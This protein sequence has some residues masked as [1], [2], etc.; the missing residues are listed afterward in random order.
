[1]TVCRSSDCREKLES[2]D[3]KQAESPGEPRVAV[4]TVSY[5]LR[6]VSMMTSSKLGGYGVR[7]RM[8]VACFGALVGMASIAGAS[9]LA[10]DDGF[11][12]L[13]NGRDLSGWVVEQRAA[14]DGSPTPKG[15]PEVWSVA[16]G[17]IVC[18]GN[19]YGFLRYDRMLDDF[20]LR[21][22][23]RMAAGCNS[24]IGI[25]GVKYTG[26]KETRPSFAGYEIQLLDDGDKPAD[27]HSTGS[28]YRY[29][30]PKASAMKPAGEWNTISIACRGPRIRV[31]L[32]GQ[33]LQDVDQSTIPQLS[34]KPLSGYLSLQN[35]GHDIEFRN[36]RP[37]ELD[38]ESEEVAETDGPFRFRIQ[39]LSERLGVGYA[40]RLLD[41]N[42]DE[43]LDVA[44]VDQERVIWLENPSWKIH[45]L[46]ENQTKPDNVCFAPYDIDRDGRVDF[47]LGADWRPSDTRTSGTIQWLRSG[48][49]A[50]DLWAVHPIGQEPTVHR[51]RFANIDED[52]EQE[53]IVLPLFGAGTS[54]PEYQESGVRI[55]AYDIPDDPANDPW[56]PKIL[57]EELHVS[58]N[59][60]PTDL[61]RDGRTDLLIASFE[62]VTWLHPSAGGAW[63]HERIGAG[64]QE[65][66]PN[67]GASEIKHGRLASGDDYIATIEPWHGTQVVVYTRPASNSGDGMWNRI[68]LDE[69]LKW[70]HAVWCA[71]LD[72]DADE[73][74]IIGVRDDKDPENPQMRRGLRI[75]DPQDAHG[76]EWRRQLVDA[77]SVAIED[78]AAADLNDDGRTDIVAVGRQTHNVRVYWNLG[79]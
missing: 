56:V 12:D 9:A 31:E 58:H 62:G 60:W 29:V 59:F 48:T 5:F 78:L 47:A 38:A 52:D 49:S 45:T 57:S 69:E 14:P 19:G 71:N 75:Y 8:A 53:L 66:S 37:K 4:C 54:R 73:E 20:E 1:M 68:V 79:P 16:E 25:R 26:P 42:E 10:A 51:M 44:V 36:V 7:T 32:N 17:R 74:L 6:A 3:G 18:E 61:D 34:D 46:I 77:G 39:E 35:H 33:L 65:T 64:N 11:V 22:E 43:R 67:R 76:R 55:L 13:F 41:M 50:S 40:V 63:R 15:T 23:F 2:S 21:V 72:G 27:E 30:A 28:L 24:G 70:G